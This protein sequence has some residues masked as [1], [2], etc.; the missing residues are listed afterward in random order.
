VGRL[1]GSKGEKMSSRRR[2]GRWGGYQME[3]IEKG[4]GLICLG[5]PHVL[6]AKEVDESVLFLSRRIHACMRRRIHA[7]MRRRIHAC[8]R[9]RIHAC[10]RR[11]I[12]ACMRRRIHACMSRRI[13]ACM[14]MRIHACMRRIHACI[15]RRIHACMRRIQ[16]SR[17]S[18][19]FLSCAARQCF[20][21]KALAFSSFS[22]SISLSLSPFCRPPVMPCTEG[23]F[24][25]RANAVELFQ[26]RYGR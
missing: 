2:Q 18:V 10:M 19:L 15:R 17:P 4:E 14:K 20:T 22:L 24:A 16:R 1:K 9:R 21:A 12:H 7:C 6:G 8:M 11:R 13:H 5:P 26:S 3:V 25:K 23:E